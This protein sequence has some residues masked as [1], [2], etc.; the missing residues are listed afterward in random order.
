MADNV[1]NADARPDLE[2]E[3]EIAP[4]EPGTIDEQEMAEAEAGCGQTAV[5][6]PMGRPL[7]HP[8][9]VPMTGERPAGHPGGHP[10]GIPMERQRHGCAR[11]V[12]FRPGG[13]PAAIAYQERTGIKAPRII[14]LEITRS[15]N[16]SCAHCRAAVCEIGRAH[17]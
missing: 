14:A 17:V 8:A 5:G 15:C 4:D 12:C 16:L 13:G 7:G 11:S 9:G 10:T 6:V 2:F 3:E 1:G